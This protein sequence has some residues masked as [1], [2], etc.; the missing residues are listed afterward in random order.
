MKKSG[1]VPAVIKL[2]Q[3]MHKVPER[4]REPAALCD[5]SSSQELHNRY[6][7]NTDRQPLI[8]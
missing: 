2:V 1:H 5:A 8:F 4:D 3:T 7:G 6:E